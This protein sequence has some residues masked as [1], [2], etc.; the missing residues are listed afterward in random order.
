MLPQQTIRLAGIFTLLAAL[1]FGACSDGNEPGQ[2]EAKTPDPLEGKLLILQAYGSGEGPNGAISHSFVEL[3]NTTDKAVNLTGYTL[4]YAEGSRTSAEADKDGAWEQIELSGTIPAKGS[5][6]VLGARK[7]TA[8]PRLNIPDTDG[9]IKSSFVLSGSAFKAALLHST[10]PLSVQNPFDID[11]KGKKAAGYIDMLGLTVSTTDRI[12]GYE[13]SPLRIS[14]GAAARRNRIADTNNNSADYKPQI[15]AAGGISSAEMERY[16]PK[17]ADFGKWD[18]MEKPGEGS[19]GNEDSLE[20]KLLILQAYGSGDGPGGAGVNRSFVELYNTTATAIDLSGITLYY[21]NGTRNTRNES[22]DSIIIAAE[23]GPWSM[24]SLT[25]TIP[26]QGSY[27]ILGPEKNTSA[28][29]NID[30]AYGDITNDAFVL[31]NR[32][33]KAALLRSADILTAQNPFDIDGEGTKIDAYIDMAGAANTYGVAYNN[34][35]I[36]GYEKAPARNSASE[37]IRRKSLIDSNDNAADFIAARYAA[38]GM[39]DEELAVRKP[40][41][42][43]RGAWD[44]FAGQTPPVDSGNTLLIFQVYGAGAETD[45]SVSHTF[46]E[47][48]NNSDQAVNISAYSLQYANGTSST[49]PAVDDWTKIDLTGSIPAHGSFL[50][51]GEKANTAARLQIT[52]TADLS[53]PGF[54]LSNRSFKVALMAN[55]TLLTVPNPFDIGAGANAPA[56]VDMLAATNTGS[57]DSIDAAEGTKFNDLSKQKAI[58]RKSLID[59][60]NN[61]NDFRSVDYRTSGT[62]DDTLTQVRPRNAAAESYTP[63]F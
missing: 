36:H 6:L 34:D 14:A 4:Q 56:Y 31:S 20:G 61:A 59:S 42:S 5:F 28:R 15:Y 60:N 21:A 8:S 27:L 9:D 57:A 45:G 39:S 38:D 3:Y 49:N 24:L 63:A 53:V 26:A 30:A 19:T 37:A 22:N 13:K 48:Y 43:S 40:E 16:R 62:N 44:P 41:N 50:I 52:E 33:F 25:G 11:G 58:R 47:L 55:Q 17:N 35:M 29:Y 23:D 7:N 12:L 2:E 10:K 46:V 54:T 32:S 51:L 1:C 18:P